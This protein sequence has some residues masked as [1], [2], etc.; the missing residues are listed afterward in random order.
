MVGWLN[1]LLRTKSSMPVSIV[2]S[3]VSPVAALPNHLL[4]IK[5]STHHSEGRVPA[6]RCRKFET[7]GNYP[8]LT[9]PAPTLKSTKISRDLG[10]LLGIHCG[11]EPRGEGS[12]AKALGAPD[13]D[14]I[15]SGGTGQ[16]ETEAGAG[17]LCQE[18]VCKGVPQGALRNHCRPAWR[19]KRGLYRLGKKAN[20]TQMEPS[21]PQPA[22]LT[23]EGLPHGKVTREQY[24]VFFPCCEI[25]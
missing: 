19:W 12:T 15:G 1:H 14:Q 9:V 22:F 11:F 4:H 20:S 2:F 10:F 3:V 8:M 13:G 7:K 6:S 23:R 25:N 17:F 24:R 18:L 16:L 21:S 5:D